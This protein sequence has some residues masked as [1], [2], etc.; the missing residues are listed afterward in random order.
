MFK[1]YLIISL[2][3]IYIF[4]LFGCSQQNQLQV[5]TQK[6]EVNILSK[7]SNNDTYEEESSKIA[8]IFPSNVIGK[9]AINAT[10]SA[11]S[12]LI[13]KNN[14]FNIQVFD[15]VVENEISI[16]QVFQQI[17]NSKINKV[18]VLLTYN[19]AIHLKKI[20]NIETYEMYMPLI[21]KNNLNL[22]LESVVYGSINYQKQFKE[23]LEYSNG[24]VINYYDNTNLGNQLTNSLANQ[25]VSINYKRKIMSDNGKY[26]R[27][28]TPKNRKLKN[29]TLIV[30]MPIVKSS[31][32]L[33]QINAKEVE[34]NNILSTQLNYTPLLL[35][36][37]QI[38]DRKNMLIANSI[39]YTNEIIEEYNA[40]LDNDIT[41]NWVNYS[42]II[43]LEYL[44]EKNINIFKQ[45]SIQNNQIQYPVK[46]YT[47]TK[48][49]FKHF[50]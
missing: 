49:A 45:V 33:S 10:N 47:T 18:I 23:L 15:C 24:K 3:F 34:I 39:G 6:K 7:Q 29:S 4:I 8:I 12:Y 50:N 22:N 41:Y 27:F 43:G 37:T 38:Q 28:L 9:Y 20:H 5:T 2:S 40:L 13:Y 14:N 32:I 1:K 11:M 19:G 26:K 46:L 44:I 21:H 30:N 31:I 35:S 48:Y 42:T 25:K 16:K 36:L 17:S